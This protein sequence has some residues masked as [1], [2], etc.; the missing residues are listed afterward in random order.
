MA[1]KKLAVITARADDRSQKDI[2]CG[3]AEAALA[4]DCDVV[5][6]TNIYNHWV[7]DELLTFE[8]VIYSFFDPTGFDGVIITA[9]A[10]MDL[11]SL[12]EA[13]EK[14]R[15]AK[16]P[17]VVINGKIEG[18]KDI[19]C[20]DVGDME[21][22]CEHLI[23]AHDV[24]DI[25]ILTGFKDSIFSHRRLLGCRK[26]FEKHGLK[27]DENKVY[28]G[29]FW[30][31][32]GYELAQ[33][34]ISGE[35]ALPQAIVCAN[36]CM[37]YQLCDDLTSAGIRIPDDVIV[38][39]YDCTGGRIYHH[40]VIT[41][42]RS[43][44]REIGISAVNYLLEAEYSPAE[45]DRFMSGD[46]CPCGTNSSELTKEITLEHL[47]HPGT[48]VGNYVQFSTAQFAQELT[49]SRTL[50]EYMN[51]INRYFFFH[52]ANNLFFCLDKDWNNA[53]YAGNE[54]LC[55]VMNGADDLQEMMTISADGLLKAVTETS[56]KPSVYYFCP[57]CFQTR[58]YG[59][60]AFAYKYPER[61]RYQI[62]SWNQIVSNALEFLRLKNDIHYLTL[63]QRTSSLYDALTGF[64]KI[65]EFRR[66]IKEKKNAN[67]ALLAV[68]ISFAPYNEN[69]FDNNRQ[70]DIISSTAMVIKQVCT[71]HE[72]CCRTEND[73]FIILCNENIAGIS[74]RLKVILH[75]VVYIRF[76]DNPPVITVEECL[77][78]DITSAINAVE[79][80]ADEAV[81]QCQCGEEAT[82]HSGLYELRKEIMTSPQDA[83]DIDS[84]SRRLCISKG[85]F[86]SIY[87]KCFGT[88]Y[89]QDCINEKII[90][91]KYL[92]CTS[93][94]SIY[95]IAMKCGYTDEKYFARQFHQNVGCSPFQYRKKYCGSASN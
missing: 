24:T 53:E 19:Y 12:S 82:Q 89:V 88:S 23:T 18:F 6:V 90:L 22:I 39:G 78:T 83:P 56:D 5:V 48:F 46:T 17:A 9:E 13:V 71:G 85:Y 34:Y 67:S 58:L 1:E 69:V 36:D 28:Y 59:Y 16:I 14:I 70:N 20:D 35:L 2:I 27:I 26:A 52:E 3:I 94:M 31:N 43:G 84:A 21:Q 30:Y 15:K 8:N 41:T 38:T 44:R 86:R 74:E 55:C 37:A 51:V 32:S 49:L 45:G 25:D 57:L 64:Y 61:F 4:A 66:I 73:V 50:P 42:Y 91:A 40:P 95:A 10:F 65:Q 63:C 33:R 68:K 47:E 11:S 29:D 77:S 87:R 60:T 54:Y 80:S 76:Y 7:A 81:M 79:K 72:S 62:R 92:L 75:R 93:V